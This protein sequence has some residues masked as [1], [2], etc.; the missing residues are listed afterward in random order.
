MSELISFLA[1]YISN[2]WIVVAIL[3]FLPITEVRVAIL[4]GLIAG[5]DHSKLFLIAAGAN[6]LEVIVLFLIMGNKRI[7]KIIDR[8][9]GKKIEHNIKKN[10]KNF[11]KYGELALVFLVASPVPGTGAI[12]GVFAAKALKLDKRWSFVTICASILISAALVFLAAK[13]FMS[14]FGTVFI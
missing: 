6:I 8:K 10:R 2:P 7:T 11:E 3:G 13:F 9:I 12:V 4:Y 14:L 1:N 5:L